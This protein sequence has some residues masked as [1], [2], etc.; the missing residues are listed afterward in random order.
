MLLLALK[1]NEGIINDDMG[2]KY[3]QWA[4]ILESLGLEKVIGKILTIID[5]GLTVTQCK[6]I[7]SLALCS[8]FKS[9]AIVIKKWKEDS[10]ETIFLITDR[11]H[12]IKATF[13]LL[14]CLVT[15]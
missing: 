5:S 11:K 12:R 7:L 15:L 9:I 2:V 13:H 14:G 8:A 4:K 10:F 6:R 1:N 3:E